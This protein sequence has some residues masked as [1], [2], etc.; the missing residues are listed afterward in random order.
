MHWAF[1][2]F[3]VIAVVCVAAT[4]QA[5]FNCNGPEARRA[6]RQYLDA[7]LELDPKLDRKT[8]DQ[9]TFCQEPSGFLSSFV[10]SSFIAQR[11]GETDYELIWASGV[12]VRDALTG[13]FASRGSPRISRMPAR[14]GNGATVPQVEPTGTPTVEGPED[15][16]AGDE[17]RL[18]SGTSSSDPQANICDGRGQV[19]RFDDGQGPILYVDCIGRTKSASTPQLGLFR[20]FFRCD[21]AEAKYRLTAVNSGV[22]TCS[23]L[24]GQTIVLRR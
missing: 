11:R 15:E 1:C 18:F 23:A 9:D 12:Y 4:S 2:R 3:V 7:V 14:C 16:C 20:G 6:V 21:R 10:A 19:R 22:L 24:S 8:L 13:E 17:L 5:A